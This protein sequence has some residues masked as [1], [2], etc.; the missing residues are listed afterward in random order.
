MRCK[1]EAARVLTTDELRQDMAL[2]SARG[3][4]IIDFFGG[5]Y[6]AKASKRR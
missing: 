2:A 6:T 4:P 5:H 3:E 1:R